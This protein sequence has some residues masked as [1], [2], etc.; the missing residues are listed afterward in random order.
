[1]LNQNSIKTVAYLESILNYAEAHLGVRFKPTGK[2]RYSAFCPFHADTKDSFRLY[3]DGNDVVRFHC[4]GE[5]KGDWDIYDVIILR[6]K[7]S[8]REAQRIWAEYLGIKDVEFHSG[9]SQKFPAP[10]T[11]PEPDDS[12]A[13]L[14]PAE[15]DNQIKATLA[16]AAGF[17][18]ELLLSDP[19]KYSKVLT[20]LARRGLE[21]PIIERFQIGYSPAYADEI[22]RGRALINGFLDRFNSEHRTFRIFQ[23]ACLVRLLNDEN[24][25]GYGYYRQQIDFTTHNPFARNYG[26]YFA[27]R[28][29]FPIRNIAGEVIGIIGRRPDNRG[30][31]WLKQQAGEG[32]ITTKSWLYGID[33]A[34]RFIK[35][36]RTVILV[37]GIFDYFFFYG[38]LQDQGRPVVVS[39]LGSYLSAEAMGIFKSLGV[40]HF[41]V[42]YDWDQ[43]GRKGI[44]TI[45]AEVGGTVYY[46]GGMQPGQDPAEKLKGVIGSISGFSLKHLMASAKKH[47]PASEKPIH[48]SFISCGP[49]DKRDITFSP[50]EAES[51]ALRPDEADA[52]E[53]YYDVAD[54]LPMLSYD[55]GNKA[56]LDQTINEIT[57]LLES[58]PTAPQSES[59]FTIP[60]KFMQT[61]AYSDLGPALILWLRLVI[62]QQA[63]KRRVRQTDAVLA[64]WLGTTRRT[65]TTY[66]RSL[67]EH[68]YLK[69][70][71]STRPQRLSVRY[72]PK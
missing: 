48:M 9:R 18:N 55:H 29:V 25:R 60:V 39:T 68:G 62:E 63:K 69:I 3:V 52:N 11:E 13:F 4:F 66:K 15:P 46:L 30:I 17:Y 71:T 49:V 28:I 10:D 47:Q 70:D 6:E 53:Y 2:Y 37:E 61:E 27:G 23:D 65:I 16:E 56:I 21:S 59:F 14:K 44:E 58:R 26:D 64:E 41:I 72:F 24:A 8:F 5:C 34:Y 12:V 32:A 54:F 67:H 7:C 1:M 19:E 57:K 35:H 31:R 45:A 51:A 20:Y 43:A 50:A 42:A 33:K 36:Y 38:L 22:Y 40:E